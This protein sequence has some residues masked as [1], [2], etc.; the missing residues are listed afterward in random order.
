MLSNSAS[1]ESQPWPWL[2]WK[3]AQQEVPF[4]LTQEESLCSDAIWVYKWGKVSSKI[5]YLLQHHMVN[6]GEKPYKY[7]ECEQAFNGKHHL[8]KHQGIHSGEKP[9]KCEECC[10]AFT[11]RSMY[12]LHNRSHT[13]EKLF[14]CKECGKAFWDRLG[15]IWHYIVHSRQNPYE[16]F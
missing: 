2:L 14:V 12:I 7:M 6:T 16:C 8:T 4:C 1:R 13:L 3:C 11:H 15:F 10:R 9:Y 5:T